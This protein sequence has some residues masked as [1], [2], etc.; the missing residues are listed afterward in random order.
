M[1]VRST[2]ALLAI[3]L[4]AACAR[5]NSE[6]DSQ[7]GRSTYDGSENM[8]PASRTVTRAATTETSPLANDSAMTTP[9]SQEPELAAAPQAS[10]AGTKDA[11]T[12]DAGPSDAGAKVVLDVIYVPTPQPIVDKMLELARVK[13]DDLVYDLGCGDGRIVVTA[14]KRYG[15]RAIGFDI[16]PVRVA[17]AKKNVEKNKVGHLVTIEQKDIFTLDLTPASVVTLYL[18]PKLNDRLL[19][20]LEALKPGSRVVSH[21][22]GIS[23]IKPVH[24]IDMR[25]RGEEEEH[26]VFFYTIPFERERTLPLPRPT[27]PPPT[28]P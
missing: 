4:A 8:V 12:K 20:Q 10:D 9:P 27:V 1:N 11:G 21:N 25:P 24:A 17:E 22:Y 28:V 15:A 6:R 3:A 18:L 7:I 19:P 5:S 13:K 14:A 26:S 23:G 16:D 2:P